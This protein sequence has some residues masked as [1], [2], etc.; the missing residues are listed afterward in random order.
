MIRGVDESGRLR[1][2][3]LL[4]NATLLA[5]AN[6]GLPT[7]TADGRWNRALKSDASNTLITDGLL[8]A[9][10]KVVPTPAA[11]LLLGLGRWLRT[12]G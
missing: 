2:W 3:E 12:R 5:S 4:L 6:T 7:P 9:G 10:E 1:S 8:P 11:R